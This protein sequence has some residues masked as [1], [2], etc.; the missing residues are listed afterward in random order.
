MVAPERDANGPYRS[1]H[2][3]LTR[4]KL[5]LEQIRI[6]IRIGAFR[7]TGKTKQQLLWE[8]ML[9]FSEKKANQLPSSD[10]LFQTEPKEYPL[11][12]LERNPLEDAFDEMELLG[13]PLLDPFRLLP[14]EARGDT[15]A[16]ELMQKLGKRVHVVGYVVTTKDTRTIDNKPMHFGTFYDWQGEVFDTVHFPNI[17]FKYPFRGRGFYSIRGKV[18]ED[19]GVS[20]VEV[21]FMEKLPMVNPR[22]TEKVETVSS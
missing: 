18:V 12:Y 22:E 5:G 16:N 2:H 9:Y 19:F 11:P 4:I 10:H 20:M 21:D 3:F 13:F 17:A 6:L 8:A 1:L 7:F 14:G 15:V